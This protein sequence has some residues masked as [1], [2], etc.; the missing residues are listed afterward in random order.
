MNNHIESEHEKYIKRCL[1]LAK[2]GKAFVSPNPMVGAVIVYEGKIIGEGYH[3]KYGKAHAEVN[4]INSVK[5][6]SLLKNSVLYVS[7][8]P[9]SHFGK[10][11][12]CSQLIID[13]KIPQVVIATLDPYYKVSGRGVKMLNEAGVETIVG[14]LEDEAKDLN[15]EFFMTQIAGRPYVYLKWAQTKDGF[16]DKKRDKGSPVVPTPIS[17]DLTKMLV[18]KFR[19]R[20]SA[21]MI[22]TNTAL[23][24]NPSL[25]TRLWWGKNPVRVI[26]D[27][28]GR[29]P[30]H[31]ELKNNKVDTFIFTEKVTTEKQ[32]EKTTYLPLVFGEDMLSDLLKVLAD[33]KINSLLVEGGASLLQSFIDKG[34]WDEVYIE[35][36]DCMFEDGVKAPLLGGILI[37]QKQIGQS[38][39]I[40]LKNSDNYKIL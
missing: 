29:I 6:K 18:H 26:L 30:N 34:L 7:L 31:Y 33:R 22:A 16:M 38:S 11:P 27:R 17:N 12:P 36:S 24:D 28:T 3:Q 2:N 35:T 15:K 20:V 25:T 21:I 10:T 19:A 32:E 14:I 9:C 23:N 40:H 39:V 5:D 8:E 1:Q 13:S 37:N 4:A